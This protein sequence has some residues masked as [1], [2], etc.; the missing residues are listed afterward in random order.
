MAGVPE[1]ISALAGLAV[2]SAVRGFATRGHHAVLRLVQVPSAGR[3]RRMFGAS[4]ALIRLGSGPLARRM[5]PR[6]LNRLR[7]RAELAGLDHP[8]EA[9]I[10]A[11][12]ALAASV[13]APCLLVFGLAGPQLLAAGL[14]A[15]VA[16]R[17]PDL[18][19]ARRARRR[20]ERI[21][22][23]V[24]DL[25]ELLVA[26]TEA[27]LSPS[28]AFRRSAEI[29]APPLGD[30]LRYTVR[31]MD[32]GVPWREALGQL[33]DRT[34]A[35]ALRRLVATLG[36][37]QRLGASIGGTLRG[38]AA[39]FRADRRARAEERARRAP[40][41]ML[42]PLVLLILPAFILLTVGPVFLATLRSLH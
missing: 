40:V 5:K 42:F 35:T 21:E 19:L 14:S 11:K 31:Q 18:V 38:V 13:P 27:G 30:E 37:S 39:D 33:A 7:R 36:R 12:V 17:M 4:E 34:E 24:A 26:T 15:L 6:S 28:V 23:Y 9:V 3:G 1:V 32:L 10:G 41:K 20:Q 8:V 29:M 2:L 16:F 25:V 22:A